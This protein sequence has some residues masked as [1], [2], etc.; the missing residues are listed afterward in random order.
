M[1][2]DR[3]RGTAA[4][5]SESSTSSVAC[6]RFVAPEDVR[7]LPF[8]LVDVRLDVEGKGPIGNI[9]EAP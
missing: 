8:E 3:S 7:E 9:D 1:S 5:V 4:A 6:E 2:A